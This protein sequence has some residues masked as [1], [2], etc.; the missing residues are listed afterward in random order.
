MKN[1][2]KN[3]VINS[4]TIQNMLC[5]ADLTVTCVCIGVCSPGTVSYDGLDNGT[6]DCR[7]CPRGY[8][9]IN[10]TTC[11]P[12][13]E[14]FSTTSLGASDVTNCTHHSTLCLDVDCGTNGVC[15]VSANRQQVC[16]CNTGEYMVLINVLNKFTF[17]K[18]KVIWHNFVYFSVDYCF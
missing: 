3:I 13:N 7:P 11:S 10:A 14:G 1:S 9:S 6:G 4:D 2:D 16:L 15:S 17:D 5:L 8:Y 12:C 18:L